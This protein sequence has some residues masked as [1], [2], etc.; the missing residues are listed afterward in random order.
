[1][2]VGGNY[3]LKAHAD[4][5]SLVA[6]SQKSVCSDALDDIIDGRT[7][8]RL[9]VEVLQDD[10]PRPSGPMLTVK[11][12]TRESASAGTWKITRSFFKEAQVDAS[13][14]RLDMDLYLGVP[15]AEDDVIAETYVVDREFDKEASN[16]SGL[17][18]WR[19]PA[20]VDRSET[21]Q[22]IGEETM[23][24]VLHKSPCCLEVFGELSPG[25]P[26][27]QDA[28]KQLGVMYTD[29]LRLAMP[30]APHD[31]KVD[32]EVEQSIIWPSIDTCISES[33]DV[34]FTPDTLWT[35][36]L[37][38]MRTGTSAEERTFVAKVLEER[39]DFLMI[40]RTPIE[41]TLF[42]FVDKVFLRKEEWSFTLHRVCVEHRG[43]GREYLRDI[44]TTWFHYD[45]DFRI[46]V[47]CSEGTRRLHG[48]GLAVGVQ[49]VLDEVM[50][51]H[52]MGDPQP[53]AGDPGDT[54]RA[55]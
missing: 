16:R 3:G 4:C 20:L 40:K 36:L 37:E 24:V 23:Y 38:V 13:L 53:S 48:E 10:T 52:E 34:F 54:K 35:H 1:M 11:S 25:E 47:A 49:C 30:D 15:G 46:E 12:I 43:I 45:P 19:K 8:W 21:L 14:R 51:R 42:H 18:H 6:H 2:G 44:Q 5:V 31:L 32:F 7:F 50:R 17:L 27:N 41:H 26:C 22:I 9:M 33:L 39:D 29:A 55:D 28:C